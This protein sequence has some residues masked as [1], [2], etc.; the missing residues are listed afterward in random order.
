MVLFDELGCYRLQQLVT[1][2]GPGW[3][4]S[5]YY[6]WYVTF[7]TFCLW[8]GPS[9]IKCSFKY[10][11]YRESIRQNPG[12]VSIFT[13]DLGKWSKMGRNH[14]PTSCSLGWFSSVPQAAQG[15]RD[16]RPAK[17]LGSTVGWQYGS[18]SADTLEISRRGS[19]KRCTY[20]KTCKYISVVV[21]TRYIYIY[22]YIQ[23]KKYPPA[24]YITTLPSCL[25]LQSRWL[26]LSQGG[27]WTRPLEVFC[28]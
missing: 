19:K 10:G 23:Y 7:C 20:I 18:G 24:S 16:Q 9:K 28:T 17:Y 1:L 27:I 21:P 13:T 15:S 4:L 5:L 22:K 14:Q 25:P 8:Y 11:N 2:L 3:L 12:V 26:S 6:T